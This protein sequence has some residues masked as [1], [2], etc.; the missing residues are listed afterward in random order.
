MKN[1]AIVVQAPENTTQR[2]NN[3]CRIPERA[4]TVALDPLLLGKFSAAPPS[5]DSHD[6]RVLCFKEIDLQ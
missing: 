3:V 6:E 5:S 1:I 2:R 4:H